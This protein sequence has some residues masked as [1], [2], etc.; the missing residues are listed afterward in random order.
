[1]APGAEELDLDGCGLNVRDA[2]ME[3]IFVVDTASSEAAKVTCTTTPR[4]CGGFGS[5]IICRT[6]I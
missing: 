5:E 4:C 1:M 2:V 6:L 3:K